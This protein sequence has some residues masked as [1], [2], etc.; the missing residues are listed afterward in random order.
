MQWIFRDTSPR[1]MRPTTSAGRD[2]YEADPASPT[3]P[4]APKVAYEVIA[5]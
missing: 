2:D 4:W 3:S 5:G 1:A